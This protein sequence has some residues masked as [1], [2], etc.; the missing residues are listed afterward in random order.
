MRRRQGVTTADLTIQIVRFGTVCKQKKIAFSVEG[1]NDDEN[2]SFVFQ[3]NGET[4]WHLQFAR[5]PSQHCR[6]TSIAFFGWGKY[7]RLNIH[8]RLGELKPFNAILCDAYAQVDEYDEEMPQSVC[9]DCWIKTKYFHE[10]YTAAIKAKDIFLENLAKAKEPTFMESDC[11][12]P[13]QELGIP[14]L[15]VVPLIENDASSEQAAADNGFEVE[16]VMLQSHELYDETSIQLA[17]GDPDETENAPLRNDV[18]V[19]NTAELPIITTYET[20]HGLFQN[21]ELMTYDPHDDLAISDVENDEIEFDAS[22]IGSEPIIGGDL[23]VKEAASLAK[24]V[25]DKSS[26]EAFDEFM[27]LIPH[28]FDMICELCK[29]EFKS[30]NEVFRH[31]R[32]Q[33]DNAKINVKCCLQPV[34]S[35]DLRDHILNHLHP[36][37]YKWVLDMRPAKALHSERPSFQVQQ[38]RKKVHAGTAVSIACA[39]PSAPTVEMWHLQKGFLVQE[40]HHQAHGHRPWTQ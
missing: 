31:Y 23:T 15:E 2:L 9:L 24:K 22:V 34:N 16:H 1:K 18:F 3:E 30:L 25:N 32:Y 29:Y 14:Y 11:N 20:E 8:S 4:N 40:R 33:H 13:A 19:A 39:N 21:N 36:D 12:S 35:A 5:H 27:K 6:I 26:K 10:F 7:I 17:A 28:Y 38:M 37:L